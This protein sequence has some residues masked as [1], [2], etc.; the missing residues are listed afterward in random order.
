MLK[1][2]ITKLVID[3]IDEEYDNK[4]LKHFEDPEEQRQYEMRLKIQHMKLRIQKD[5][6]D[7]KDE[8]NDSN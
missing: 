3:N 5:K 1:E 4:P 8:K 6:S 2:L 7:K